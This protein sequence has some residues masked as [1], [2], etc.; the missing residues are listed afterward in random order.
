MAWYAYCLTEHQT[1]A[2]GTRTRRPSL[3]EGVQGVNG[4]PV[5]SYPSGEFAVVVSEFDRAT[6]KLDEKTVLEHARVVSACFRLSTVLPFRFGTIFD[7]EEALRQAVRSNRRTFGESV[8]KLRGKAEM[9]LKLVVRDGSLREAM[10]DIELPNT[11]GGEYL[12]KLRV[13]ASRERERQTKARALSVQVHKLFN[14]LEEEVSCKK[15]D[16]DGMLLDI[17]HLIDSKS[18]EKYQNR[19]TTAAKQLKNC[20]LVISGPWPPYHFMPG[21]L[22]TVAG[23]S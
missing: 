15:V 21:K 23:N 8:A 5:V 12:A 1:L 16:A 6:D 17:A 20:E 19:Y 13:K 11:V 22:R 2:N 10:T 14:P 9:R 7:T 3:L 4:A 18:I